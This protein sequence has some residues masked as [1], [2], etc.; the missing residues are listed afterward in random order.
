M[1][2]IRKIKKEEARLFLNIR[3]PEMIYITSATLYW[4]ALGLMVTIIAKEAEIFVS[5]VRPMKRKT[6]LLAAISLYQS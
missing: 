6:T 4:R 1:R 3:G 2:W 5:F